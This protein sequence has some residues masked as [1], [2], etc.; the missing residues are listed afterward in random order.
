MRV[1]QRWITDTF[2]FPGIHQLMHTLTDVIW[3]PTHLQAKE[4][5]CAMLGDQPTGRSLLNQGS[6]IRNA[7]G[8]PNLSK[9]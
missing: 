5:F 9:A 2:C 3:S 7:R 6:Q 8:P 1:G 4:T